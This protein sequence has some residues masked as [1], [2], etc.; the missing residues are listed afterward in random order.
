[1][2]QRETEWIA[3]MLKSIAG[4]IEKR[5]WQFEIGDFWIADEDYAEPTRR[6]PKE[7]FRSQQIDDSFDR[8][9]GNR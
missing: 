4:R 2:A 5:D 8:E 1:M 6:A 7:D 9:R 3:A